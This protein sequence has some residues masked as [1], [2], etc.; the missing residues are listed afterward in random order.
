[1]HVG[2][3]KKGAYIGLFN[4]EVRIISDNLI[5]AAADLIRDVMEGDE[6]VITFYAGKEAKST[7]IKALEVR[8]AKL[9]PKIDTEIHKGGQP[10]YPFIFSI[11]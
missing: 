7:D 1:L 5:D 4:G 9:F 11:E 8:I 10:L 3:I 2:E 6:E